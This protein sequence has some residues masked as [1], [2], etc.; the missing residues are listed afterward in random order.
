MNIR[1]LSLETNDLV[2]ELINI[3][4]GV[5]KVSELELAIN[6]LIDSASLFAGTIEGLNYETN[7]SVII[8]KVNQATDAAGRT[9]F[10]IDYLTKELAIENVAGGLVQ[11]KIGMVTH[12]LIE[13]RVAKEKN[14]TPTFQGEWLLDD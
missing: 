3:A 1:D 8:A 2:R 11:N 10:W 12:K 4:R 7:D 14:I 9:I 5:E 13:L 6:G